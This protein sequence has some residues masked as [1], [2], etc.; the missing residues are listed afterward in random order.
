M[1]VF[2]LFGMVVALAAIVV[3]IGSLVASSVLAA[4]GR[5]SGS[6]T[7]AWAGAVGSVLAA[8]ALTFCCGL[9]VFCFLTEDATIRYVLENQ[10]HAEGALGVL[11]RVSGLWAGREGSLLFWGW[12]ISVF[13]A[14]VAARVLRTH[15]RLDGTALL[16]SN[17]V[18][19]AFVSVSLFS[20]S[21]MPFAARPSFSTRTGSFAAPRSCGA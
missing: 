21:N 10:S 16:V 12:L 1:A 8:V 11:Y 4:R 7:A 18:L 19:L 13:N 9:L 5:A 14:V 2:G 15:E 17:V 3:S 20:E 6:E